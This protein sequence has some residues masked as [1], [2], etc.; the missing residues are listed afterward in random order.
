MFEDPSIPFFPN[1]PKSKL[2][3]D[4]PKSVNDWVIER[5]W[6][7]ISNSVIDAVS[8]SVRYYKETCPPVPNK[9]GKIALV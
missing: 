5:L 2:W 6:M 9:V 4:I 8:L 3:K 7:P 1:V